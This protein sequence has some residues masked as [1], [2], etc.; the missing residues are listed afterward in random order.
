MAMCAAGPPKA[1]MPSFRKSIASSC[2]VPGFGGGWLMMELRDLPAQHLG[3]CAG[4]GR[5]IPRATV[6]TQPGQPGKRSRFHTGHRPAGFV[7][8]NDGRFDFMPSKCT[9]NCAG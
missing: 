6:V 8:W 2:N 3:H 1:V 4:G 9:N 7:Y 5:K